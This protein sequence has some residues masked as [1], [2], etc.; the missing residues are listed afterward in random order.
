MAK[1][2]A[3]VARKPCYVVM[4]FMRHGESAWAICDKRT[5]RLVVTALE[6]GAAYTL[7]HTLNVADLTV[8]AQ[9]FGAVPKPS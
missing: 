3:S 1:P 6:M 7:A 8:P 4:A 2:T 9:D 5:G